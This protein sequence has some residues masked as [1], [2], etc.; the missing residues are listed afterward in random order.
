MKEPGRA[1]IK[2]RGGAYFNGHKAETLARLQEMVEDGYELPI[3]KAQFRRYVA[4]TR[5]GH[6]KT[7]VSKAEDTGLLGTAEATKGPTG[8][9]AETCS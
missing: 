4:N 7:K 8:G 6:A 9:A 3:S 2:P 1:R 5:R